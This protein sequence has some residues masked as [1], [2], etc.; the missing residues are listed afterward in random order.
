MD[1][2]L[3]FI[4]EELYFEATNLT[5]ELINE[6]SYFS[7]KKIEEVKCFDIEDYVKKIEDVEFCDYPF[8]KQLKKNM[9]GSITK[10]YD[11][12]II[13]TNENLVL[14]RKNFTKMHEIIHYYRDIPNI[15]DC[16]SLSDMISE[17]GYLVE[18][19]PKEYRANVG[20]SILLANEQA[21]LYAIQ[22][23][24][25]FHQVADYFFMSKSALH[26]RLKEYLIFVCNCSPQN[27]YKLVY[28]Y[29]MG[30]NNNFFNTFYSCHKI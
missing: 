9:L 28:E 18:D 27:A 24:H 6:V 20:A 15:S 21:L 13:T 29:R 22:K 4:N 17:N 12:I 26:N 19:L 3:N 7:S 2:L 23:F 8:Q 10:V 1:S 16:H 11:E 30:N 25:S 14:E 5:N